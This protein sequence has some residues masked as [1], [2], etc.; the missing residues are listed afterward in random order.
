[1]NTDKTQ[2]RELKLLVDANG[3]RPRDL[4]DLMQIASGKHPRFNPMS[5]VKAV[6]S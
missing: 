6:Q 4:Y 1:M 2:E 5:L 3:L